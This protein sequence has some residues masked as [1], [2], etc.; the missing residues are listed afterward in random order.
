[1]TRD[2]DVL[3][4]EKNTKTFK[5]PEKFYNK[6]NFTSDFTVSDI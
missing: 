3:K 5:S 2:E 1:M 6:M 4:K